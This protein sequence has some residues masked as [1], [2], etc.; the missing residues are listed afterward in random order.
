MVYFSKVKIAACILLILFSTHSL[1]INPAYAWEIKDRNEYLLDTRGDDGSIYLN[2]LSAHQKLDSFDIEISGFAE[3]QWNF[4]IDDWEKLMLGFGASKYLWKYLYLS[5]SIQFIS[6]EILDYMNFSVNSNSFD[7]TTKIGLNMPFLKNF[8]LDI[9][10]EFSFNLEKGRDEYCESVAEVLYSPKDFLSI[11]IG[12][13]HTDRIHN[14][15][16]DYVGSS[17]TLRF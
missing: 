2:R 3:A 6:G 17:I 14:L 10:E 16:T 9:S 4:E 1:L 13:R 12:W 11:G 15:D 7:A 8:A 5:Q